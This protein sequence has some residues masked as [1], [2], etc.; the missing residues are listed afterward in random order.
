M[1][2]IIL[3]L[4][5][6]LRMSYSST[7]QKTTKELFEALGKNAWESVHMN[8]QRVHVVGL[9]SERGLQL[10]G[11][12]GTVVGKDENNEGTF[13]ANLAN[14]R[15]HVKLDAEDGQAG[16][17]L[18]LK[19]QNF[20]PL[21][22]VGKRKTAGVVESDAPVL[23][24]ELVCFTKPSLKYTMHVWLQLGASQKKER[25]NDRTSSLESTLN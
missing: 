23:S 18:R 11:Q 1:S 3:C 13:N 24:M 14:L 8:G 17:V 9:A 6:F 4:Q 10:N 19:L 20:E 15:A 16:V 12:K 21:S 7:P 25:S 2:L 5:K 22:N